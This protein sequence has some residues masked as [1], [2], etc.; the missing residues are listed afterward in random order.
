MRTIHFCAESFDRRHGGLAES[1]QRILA[2]LASDPD[3][4]V[5]AYP[6]EVAASDPN[7][8]GAA[9]T[10]DVAGRS[11]DLLMPLNGQQ[12][13]IETVIE[14]FRLRT[15][16]LTNAVENE[17]RDRSAGAHLLLSFYLS[18][19]GFVAQH[20]ADRTGLPHVASSRGSDLGRDFFSPMTFAAIQHVVRSASA[21]VTTNRDHERQVR[22]LV[23][24][25]R[26]VRTIYNALPRHGHRPWRPHL[27]ERVRLV[28]VTGYSLKK[29]THILIE[30]ATRLLDE[31]LPIELSVVGSEPEQAYWTELKRNAT[32]RHPD[33][34]SFGGF[35][36]PDRIE[37]LLLDADV[38][39]AASLSEGCSNATMF[40]FGLGMPIVSTATGAL[41]DLADGCEH[42]AMVPPADVDAF[43][44]ALREFVQRIHHG[45]L[46]IDVAAVRSV[47]SRLT[48]ENERIQ[49]MDVIDAAFAS[50]G[51]RGH[52]DELDSIRVE[53]G[54]Q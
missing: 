6:M 19:S 50:A 5:V 9:R 46:R 51:Q 7:I 39:V 28:A 18:T 12:K 53:A 33:R 47:V 37:T 38:F 8:E 34:F 22:R 31:G 40:A 13:S 26:R 15:L 32:A 42:V 48:P 2:G 44:D 35:V 24:D 29:G 16:L 21:I 27:R 49:W 20:V 45:R 36:A 52:R 25:E 11:A 43:T 54:T 30:A 4:R 23:G 1:A 10:V 17:M 14:Q 3:T 41:V